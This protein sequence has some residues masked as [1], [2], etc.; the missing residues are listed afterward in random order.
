[1]FG[2][3]EKLDRIENLNRKTSYSEFLGNILLVISMIV[4][5]GSTTI[6]KKK[7]AKGEC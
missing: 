2:R 3:W 4:E 6:L 7:I 1:M 5:L